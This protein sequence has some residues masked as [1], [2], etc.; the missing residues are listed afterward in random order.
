VSE[1]KAAFEPVKEYSFIVFHDAY[2]Y[3]DKRKAATLDPLGVE[4]EPGPELYGN[5]I[6]DLAGSITTC[7]TP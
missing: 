5:V 3:F 2:Q 4:F 6:N 1:I 7:L